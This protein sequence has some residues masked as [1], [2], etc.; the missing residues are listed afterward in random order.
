MKLG[1]VVPNTVTFNTL[2]NGYSQVGNCEMNDMFYQTMLS[3]G[4]KPDILTYNALILGLCR[5]GKTKKAAYLVKEL[6]K[7]YKTMVRSGLHPNKQTFDVLIAAFCKNKDFERS[8][9]SIVG[10][11]GQVYNSYFR[12]H[13]GYLLTMVLVSVE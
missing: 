5:E 9:P 2:M 3:A 12:L 6:D 13:R 4:I 11:V 10:N 7:L 8:M 1:N